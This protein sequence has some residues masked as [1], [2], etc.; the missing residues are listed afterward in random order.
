MSVELSKELD[1]LALRYGN[2]FLL[3]EA[4][5]QRACPTTA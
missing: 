1:A 4:P 5:G 2:R 3:E